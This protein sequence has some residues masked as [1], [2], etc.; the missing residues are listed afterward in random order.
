MPKDH[1]FYRKSFLLNS[2]LIS[3]FSLPNI[4]LFFDLIS[5]NNRIINEYELKMNRI[6]GYYKAYMRRV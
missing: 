6:Y 3:A 4:R 2:H 1:I 5:N